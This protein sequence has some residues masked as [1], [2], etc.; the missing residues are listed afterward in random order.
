MLTCPERYRL[1][2]H[3]QRWE[4]E[5]EKPAFV[6]GELLH[7]GLAH[8]YMYKKY[9]DEGRTGFARDWHT[10][11]DAMRIKAEAKGGMWLHHLP[12]VTEAYKLYSQEYGWDKHWE[13]MYIE[14]ELKVRVEGHLYTQRADLIVRDRDTKLVWIVDHKTTSRI[15]NR[16]ANSFT[17]NGQFVGYNMLGRAFFKEQFGGVRLNLVQLAKEDYAF[18]RPRLAP[19]PNTNDRF[20]NTI[21]YG[22]AMIASMEATLGTDQPWPQTFATDTCIGR[23]GQCPMFDICQWGE[24]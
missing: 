17:L 18:S 4:D 13:V 10:P 20:R 9:R 16:T 24:P 6:K 3:V 8:L 12:L 1:R 23:Y 5:P 19:A 7:L 11:A 2:Q 22:E 21:L 14:K 15:T